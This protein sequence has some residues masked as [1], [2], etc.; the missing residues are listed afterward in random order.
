M[1]N[2]ELKNILHKCPLV[3]VV[4]VKIWHILMIFLPTRSTWE[5]IVYVLIGWI[6][7]SL[8]FLVRSFIW[9]FFLQKNW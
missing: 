6:P 1:T 5:D 8:G 7:G 9:R 4:V 2:L 3:G